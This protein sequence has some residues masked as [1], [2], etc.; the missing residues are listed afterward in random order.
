MSARCTTVP[1]TPL[2]FPPAESPTS[3]AIRS[4]PLHQHLHHAV[5]PATGNGSVQ[6][7]NPGNTSGV[8]TNN[9]LTLYMNRQVNA[10]TVL[11]QQH[12]RHRERRGLLRNRIGDGRRLRDPVHAHH[13]VPEQRAVQWWFSGNVQDVYGD[14]S[15]A[16]AATSTPLAAAPDPTTAAPSVVAVSPRCCG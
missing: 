15:T 1:P 9:L 12:H 5:N 16:P 4:Q 10:S 11:E 3:G 14:S 13:C 7:T 6:S 8:P 2:P